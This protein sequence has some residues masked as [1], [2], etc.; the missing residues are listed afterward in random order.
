MPHIHF[1]LILDKNCQISTPE[2]IDEYISARI[3]PLP[4]IDDMSPEAC[5]ARRLWHYV[6]SMMMHDCNKACQVMRNRNGIV[7]T[8]CSKNFPKPYADHT[9][10][11]GLSFF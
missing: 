10:L 7:E 1:L 8:V 3:P 9:E 6:T 5:Q 4:P 11:S 2:Q